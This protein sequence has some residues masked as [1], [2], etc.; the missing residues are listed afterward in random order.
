LKICADFFDKAKYAI[1]DY[2]S[3]INDKILIKK[4]IIDLKEDF[5]LDL[6]SQEAVIFRGEF[7]R[8]RN[9]KSPV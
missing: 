2:F 5:S 3:S 4:I 9:K 7:F 6:N 8:L 1:K